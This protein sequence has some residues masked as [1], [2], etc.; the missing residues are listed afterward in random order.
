MF[1]ER[2]TIALAGNPNAGKTTVFNALTGARQHVGNYPGVT[3]EKKEG[4]CRIGAREA[5]LV[6]LPGTYSLT[7]YSLEEVV[8][9][10]FIVQDKPDVVIDVADAANLERHLYLTLQ[11]LELE[12]PLVLALNMADMAEKQGLVYDLHALAAQLGVPVIPTV[13]RQE[14]GMDELL[15]AVEKMAGEPTARI[16]IDYGEQVEHVLGVL[17]T[18]LADLDSPFP[19]RWLAVKLLERDDDVEAQLRLLAGGEEVVLEAERQRR[20]LQIALN[21]EV[22]IYIAGRRYRKAGEIYESCLTQD[23]R[24]TRTISDR[25]DSIV[26]HRVLGLPIF[27]ALMWLLF[28]LVFTLGAVP[29]DMLDAGVKL[30]GET[31]GMALPEGNLRSLLVDGMIGGVGSVVSFLPDILLLF[32]AIALLEDSG[33]MARAAFVM[34]RVMRGFGLHGKSFIPMLLGFGCNVSAVMAART[35]ENEKDRYITILVSPLMSCSA[36]L[37][38]YTLLIGAFFTEDMAGTVLFG[39]YILGIALAIG[40]AFLFRKTLF[41]GDTEPFVMEMPP[42]HL[43]TLRSV[44]THMW[45]RSLIYLRKAGTII[46]A[47]SILVWFGVNYPQ[48]EDVNSKYE[49]LQSALETRYEEQLQMQVLEPLGITAVEENEELNALVEELATAEEADETEKEVAK[50]EDETAVVAVEDDS[51][52]KTPETFSKEQMSSFAAQYV[53]LKKEAEEE[54]SK[55]NKEK[56]TELL[57]QSYAGSLG[58]TIEPII[59]PLGFD[60][61][62]GVG[63]FSAFAAKEVMVSTLATIYSVEASDEEMAPLQEVLAADPSFSPLIAIS[64]MVFCLIYSPCLATVAVIKREMNSWKWAGFS[65]AYSM[66]LAWLMAFIVYQGGLLLGLGG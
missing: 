2:L 27:F 20:E 55:L 56:A 61:K 42:Y 60:W 23:R 17:G 22:D 3:V 29:K 48:N 12:R 50:A 64:L 58:R 36:R 26:T 66:T 46:L 15:V 16:R 37:P 53:V 44:L 39:I 51:K 32:F 11:L 38:V 57:A 7:A 4:Y 33:Y 8:A 65:V 62:I 25:I 49:A 13:G 35:L 6:D 19:A 21:E 47:A 28:N 24:E 63:L 40:M 18:K 5:V 34:D 41:P 9:R 54:K 1:E 14:K 43:P 31:V 10:N 59:K 30:L 52:E 45:E